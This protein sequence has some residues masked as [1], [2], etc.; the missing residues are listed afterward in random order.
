MMNR[1][2]AY[3]YIIMAAILWGIIGIF[4]TFLYERGFTP[5]QVVTIRALSAII[6]LGTYI[7][8]TNR[9]TLR[10]KFSDSKYFVGT[11]IFSFVLFNLC[12]FNTLK[13][14]SISISAILLYTAP[15]FVTILSRILFKEALTTRKIISLV[16]TFI[17]CSLVVGLFQNSTETISIYGLILGLGSG[18]FYALYSI[19]STYALRRYSPI[20]VTIYTFIFAAIAIT[21]FSGILGVLHLFSDLEVW[22]NIIGLGFISTMLAFIMYTKGL[23]KIESSK[24]SITATIEPVIAALVSFLVFKETLSFSQYIGILVVISAVIFVEMPMK[25]SPAKANAANTTI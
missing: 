20:T 23:S 3:F 21:P 17:G 14:T 6:F 7:L 24:A 5:V 4:I 8:L 2:L 1:N 18:L 22:L 16:A 25:S 15:A 12:L 10:I 9:Q 19:F 11:G 13:E